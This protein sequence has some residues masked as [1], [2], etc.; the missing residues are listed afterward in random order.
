MPIIVWRFVLPDGPHVVSVNHQPVCNNVHIEVD[1][2][3][4]HLLQTGTY[5]Q[6]YVAGR[7]CELDIRVWRFPTRYNL[8]IEGKHIETGLSRQ[9]MTGKCAECSAIFVCIFIALAFN[10]LA[11]IP[12][13]IHLCSEKNKTETIDCSQRDVL[14]GPGDSSSAKTFLKDAESGY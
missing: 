11:L 10:V 9:Q 13:M 6:F 7:F 2:R 5:Q 1:G 8:Y 14:S 4:I 12:W 3:Q